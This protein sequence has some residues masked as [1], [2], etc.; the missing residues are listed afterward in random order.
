MPPMVWDIEYGSWWLYTNFRAR[1]MI[2]LARQKNPGPVSPIGGG[3]IRQ[4]SRGSQV[5]SLFSIHHC[6]PHRGMG[7]VHPE[8]CP[9]GTK[10]DRPCEFWGPM[11]MRER[12]W[13]S[14]QLLQVM[15]EFRVCCLEIQYLPFLPIWK[16]GSIELLVHKLLKCWIPRINPLE[17]M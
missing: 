13:E 16:R 12:C 8:T 6:S 9:T 11:G 15:G 3:V 4:G 17:Q 14:E 2:P 1:M 10:R 5:P 7:A